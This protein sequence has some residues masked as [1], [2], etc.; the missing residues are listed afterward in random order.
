MRRSNT[1]VIDGDSQDKV[2]GN[3]TEKVL[4][5]AEKESFVF[6][7]NETIKDD[8]Y[9]GVVEIG[10][11]LVIKARGIKLVPQLEFVSKQ[12]PVEY[13]KYHCLNIT[14]CFSVPVE[15]TCEYNYLERV[16]DKLEKI[17]LS[18]PKSRNLK[19]VVGDEI[20]DLPAPAKLENGVF[21][22]EINLSSEII[23]NS[24][25]IYFKTEA[26]SQR[27]VEFGFVGLGECAHSEK[28]GL[29]MT[30]DISRYESL[31]NEVYEYKISAFVIKQGSTQ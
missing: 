16:D 2:G 19:L 17:E 11:T 9:I 7:E 20:T 14:N 12:Q 5:E 28:L 3:N 29:K 23:Q 13:P 21:Q 25:D 1:E 10:D 27:K 22:Y 4:N 30:G 18:D 6:F 24:T 15:D 31:V 8:T 26:T